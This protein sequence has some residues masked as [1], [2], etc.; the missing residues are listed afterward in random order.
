M[1]NENDTVIFQR[2]PQHENFRC[3]GCKHKLPIKK[4]VDMDFKF[5]P[6]CDKPSRQTMV[7]S[8]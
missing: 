7:S 6:Y 3:S 4:L 8:N 5:C 1:S 2:L